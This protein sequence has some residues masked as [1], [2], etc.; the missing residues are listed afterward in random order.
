MTVATKDPIAGFA[1]AHAA[2]GVATSDLRAASTAVDMAERMVA[3]T[4]AREREA[5]RVA[6]VEGAE[7]RVSGRVHDAQ[8]A[9]QAARE[10]LIEHKGA[11]EVRRSALSLAARGLVDGA[12]KDALAT[13]IEQL[14]DVGQDRIDRAVDEF[15][16]ARRQLA[17]AIGM[18]G[19]LDGGRPSGGLREA[20]LLQRVAGLQRPNGE[21]YGWHDVEAALRAMAPA[22]RDMLR[23][24]V[25]RPAP[26]KAPRVPLHE[27]TE[28]HRA[29]G[30]SFSDSVG[31]IRQRYLERG[32]RRNEAALD[33]QEQETGRTRDQRTW[34]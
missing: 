31:E 13:A 30:G 18:L 24:F 14:I 33:A 1:S 19:L 16:A 7:H 29:A 20:A 8:E 11:D 32:P 5:A 3:L 6:L 2:A 21:A 4:V 17:Q 10:R 9:L 26:P 28:W 25:E 12:G 27:M 22:A 34:E 15:A 23:A